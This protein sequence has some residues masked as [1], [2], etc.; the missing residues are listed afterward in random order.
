MQ[1]VVVTAALVLATAT[2]ARPVIRAGEAE[3]AAFVE[4]VA[5]SSA[6]A[7]DQGATQSAQ[8]T[9]AKSVPAT[10]RKTTMSTTDDDLRTRVVD[11]QQTLDRVLA[12]TTPAPVGTTGTVGG[13]PAS[14]MVTVERARL[15]QLREQLEALIATLNRR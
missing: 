11:I 5:S 14:G 13:T 12:D 3:K 15:L 7:T 8:P 9:R 2:A 4:Q 6:P 10:A 1:H